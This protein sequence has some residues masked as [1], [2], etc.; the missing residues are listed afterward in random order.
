MNLWHDIPLGENAPEEINT[1]IE[2]PR[3]SPNKY[4]ID[5]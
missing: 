1:I 2:I 4:E 5:K 3:G